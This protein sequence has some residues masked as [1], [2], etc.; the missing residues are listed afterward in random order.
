MYVCG[1][2]C[3]CVCTHEPTAKSQ[4]HALCKIHSSTQKNRRF[5]EI[6]DDDNLTMFSSS[7]RVKSPEWR[8]QQRRAEKSWSATL[9]DLQAWTYCNI[10]T[11]LPAG[12]TYYLI[13]TFPA[14]TW[15]A[16]L[17][18]FLPFVYGYPSSCPHAPCTANKS[19]P[20]LRYTCRPGPRYT[21]PCLEALTECSPLDFQRSSIDGKTWWLKRNFTAWSKMHL[22][23]NV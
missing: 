16:F 13:C 14:S 21:G 12:G 9:W 1:C 11:R 4:L 7:G 3:E 20:T 15:S 10:Y 6:T 23:S 17:M 19:V 8:W 2:A 5:P 22:A 18:P